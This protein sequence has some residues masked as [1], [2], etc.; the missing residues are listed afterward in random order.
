MKIS[1][2]IT[3]F[4]FAFLCSFCILMIQYLFSQSTVEQKLRTDDSLISPGIGSH[5]VLVGDMIDSVMR[6]TGREK[7]KISK[8]VTPGELFKDVFHIGT[9]IQIVFDAIYYSENNN[10][11]LCVSHGKVVAI[12]GFINTGIT[13]D[14]VSLK[15]G[16]NNFIFYYGNTNVLRIQS[17]SHGLYIYQTKGIALIDD[18]L[19]DSIDL[20]IV[21]SPQ[22]AK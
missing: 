12:I 3:L 15:S 8:P 22:I 1:L 11:A 6:T 13:T 20:Y 2:R 21:F 19:N 14:G 18:D 5:S 4:I 16:I 9:K 10:Y 7:F 17:G